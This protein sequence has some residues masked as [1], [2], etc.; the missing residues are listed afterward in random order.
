MAFAKPIQVLRLRT[1][2]SVSSEATSTGDRDLK[3]RGR[4]RHPLI[5]TLNPLLVQPGDY[6]DLS[7]LKLKRIA[8]ESS[9]MQTIGKKPSF[10]YHVERKKVPFPDQ[11][12]GFLYY[13]RAPD[14]APLEG[15]L[16][17]RLATHSPPSS[18]DL[19]LPTGM[20]WQVLL[21]QLARPFYK[22]LTDQLLRDDLVTPQQISRCR[23]LFGTRDITASLTLF[24]LGQEFP[25]NLGVART[26]TVVGESLQT[27]LINRLLT[28]SVDKDLVYPFTGS[29]IARF[30]PSVVDG[31]RIVHMRITKLVTPV[32]CT[33]PNYRGRIVEPKEG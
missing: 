31:R 14:A 32:V 7:G 33:V 1:L 21:P 11:C 3:P 29:A 10:C 2:R 9:D 18:K 23:T 30:E 22:N 27:I 5:S 28:A 8:F 26:L 4:P 15:S 13:H 19:L 16:R 6:M 25:L 17:F 12:T 20:P 24:R